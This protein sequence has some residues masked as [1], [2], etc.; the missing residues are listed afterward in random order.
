MYKK[1]VTKVTQSVVLE[2][3]TPAKQIA[4]EINKPYSTLLREVNPF[5]SSAKLGVETVLEIMKVTSDIEPLRFIA[6][7]MGFDLVPAAAKDCARYGVGDS[8]GIDFESDERIR[9]AAV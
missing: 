9:R 8:I 7:E 6:R 2:G 5:D 3:N 1:S 4:Q